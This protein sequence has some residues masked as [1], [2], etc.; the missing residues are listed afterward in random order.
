MIKRKIIVLSFAILVSFSMLQ[1]NL[2]LATN[3]TTNE[4][5]SLS[6]IDGKL[7]F[8]FIVNNL[9]EYQQNYIDQVYN[10]ALEIALRYNATSSNITIV[11]P[12]SNLQTDFNSTLFSLASNGTYDVIF[13]IGRMACHDY[14]FPADN[15]DYFR[16]L[17]PSQQIVLIDSGKENSNNG[18]G[19]NT[20]NIEISQE[21]G[22]FMAGA[23]IARSTD[24]DKFGMIVNYSSFMANEIYLYEESYLEGW[25]S[26]IKYVKP[27][28]QIDVKSLKRGN[29]GDDGI[30]DAIDDSLETRGI[31]AV[32]YLADQGIKTICISAGNASDAIYNTA[33]T[34]DINIIAVD[35]NENN[36][37]SVILSIEKDITKMILDVVNIYNTTELIEL[38]KDVLDFTMTYQIVEGINLVNVSSYIE[39]LAV[40]ESEKDAI[41]NDYELWQ[42]MILN[43]SIVVPRNMLLPNA[44][45]FTITS[46]FYSLL[47]IIPIIWSKRKKEKY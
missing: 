23:L 15:R 35:S 19:S 36:E 1:N 31:D 46:L 26:G 5:N 16:E 12:R 34:R 25:I 27:N 29:Y 17:Y 8:A 14:I 45:G 44:P 38:T 18:L 20:T 32:N 13:I 3:N 28:A 6:R 9:E 22:S 43:G 2:S 42:T 40:D 30:W 41:R 33:E 7:N 10:A 47:V 4:G 37:S 11:G 21:Q 24:E 39:N